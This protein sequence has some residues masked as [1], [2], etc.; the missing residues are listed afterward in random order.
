MNFKVH[1]I[2][3]II[4]LFATIIIIGVI[5]IVSIGHVLH[6]RFTWVKASRLST[7]TTLFTRF[8]GRHELSTS[9]ESRLATLIVKKLIGGR[10]IL[11]IWVVIAVASPE[12]LLIVIV[13]VIVSTVWVLVVVLI[14][15]L[16]IAIIRLI[17]AI[18]PS[19]PFLFVLLVNLELLSPRYKALRARFVIKV[20]VFGKMPCHLVDVNILSVGRI[21]YSLETIMSRFSE[22]IILVDKLLRVSTLTIDSKGT[23]VQIILHVII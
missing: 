11:I 15:I 12:R 13:I 21:D 6:H 16:A 19:K 9:S 4:A 23:I 1:R 3:C 17:V 5:F 10:I 7:T 14:L 20:L 8:G 22:I 2:I 18:L